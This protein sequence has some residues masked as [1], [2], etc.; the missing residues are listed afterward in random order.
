M[1]QEGMMPDSVRKNVLRAL[2]ELYESSVAKW[3]S[4][5]PLYM[6]L[7]GCSRSSSISQLYIDLQEWIL[8]GGPEMVACKEES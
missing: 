1:V 4:L 5:K 7:L 2:T 6:R 8:S 3:K